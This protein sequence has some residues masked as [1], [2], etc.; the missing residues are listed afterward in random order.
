[1]VFLTH[2]G[3]S[4][5][6]GP[7][8][9]ETWIFI[10]SENFHVNMTY[11]GSVVLEKKTLK[12]PY[13]IFAI[14]CI[15]PNPVF[16]QLTIPFTQGWFVQ[17]NFSKLATTSTQKYDWFRG[18]AGFVILPLQRNVQQGLKKSADIHG[19]PVFW[20]SGLERFHCT[21]FNWNWPAGSGDFFWI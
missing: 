11:S 21:K 14:T 12:W 7:W 1:M 2:S 3:P 13:L 20:G 4:R 10:I 9:E 8:F 5:P 19:G 15:S 6:R 18:M 17:W 16:E